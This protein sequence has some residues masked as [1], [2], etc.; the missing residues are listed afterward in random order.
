MISLLLILPYLVQLCLSLLLIMLILRMMELKLKQLVRTQI[1]DKSI[2]EAL[3]KVEKKE[4]RNPRTKRENNKKSQQKK[5]HFCHRCG[6]SGHTRPNCYKWLATQQNNSM[7]SFRNQNQFPSSF[8]SLGDFLKALMFLLN[9]N[10]FNSSPSP[11]N[12]RF[13]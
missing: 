3:L 6:A 10:D 9:L 7:L 2:L 13:A 5:P 4:G 12:Q 1:K 8:A 11:P